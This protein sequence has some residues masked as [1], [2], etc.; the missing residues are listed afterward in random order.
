MAH[1]HEK[2]VA[3]A[4]PPSGQLTTS[5]LPTSQLPTS[6]LV[7][8]TTRQ[9]LTLV[10]SELELAKA[11]LKSDLASELAAVKG[12]GLAALGALATLNLLLVAAALGLASFMPGWAAALVV[13]GIV[14]LLAVVAAGVGWKHVRAPLARTRRSLQEDARWVKERA[15]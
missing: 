6:E 15:A 13:A 8:E 5:Q 14:A 4:S 12:L 3:V 7:M 11:E 2:P 1:E 10:R 9:A